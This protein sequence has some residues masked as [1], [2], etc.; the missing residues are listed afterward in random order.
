MLAAATAMHAAS[1]AESLA[2]CAAWE[3]DE[4]EAK[5]VDRIGPRLPSAVPLSNPTRASRPSCDNSS[6]PSSRA[7]DVHSDESIASSHASRIFSGVNA[8]KK[9]QDP[10]P[11]QVAPP[12]SPMRAVVAADDAASDI[13]PRLMKESSAEEEDDSWIDAI[14][15]DVAASLSLLESDIDSAKEAA[16]ERRPDELREQNDGGDGG[17]RH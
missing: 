13:S 14:D 1:E 11:P 3:A 10:G 17:R 16:V 12:S 4:V 2:V 15:E 8:G 6:D 5:T 7:I 9:W